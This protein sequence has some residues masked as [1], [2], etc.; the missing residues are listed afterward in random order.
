MNPLIRTYQGRNVPP[1][2]TNAER[3]A[4]YR[5]ATASVSFNVWQ[6]KFRQ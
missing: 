6:W 3:L 4:M 1:P 5:A 2:L